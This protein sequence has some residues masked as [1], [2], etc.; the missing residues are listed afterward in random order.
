MTEYSRLFENKSKAKYKIDNYVRL[1]ELENPDIFYLAKVV[2][3][4]EELEMPKYFVETFEKKSSKIVNIW[5]YEDEILK[6][7]NSKEKSIFIKK[8]GE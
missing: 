5:L 3:V 6:K 7:T 2:D 1:I 8:R 4:N